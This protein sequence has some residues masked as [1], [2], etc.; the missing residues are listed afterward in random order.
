M[1]FLLS[2][3]LSFV[4]LHSQTYAINGGPD[5]NGNGGFTPNTIGT[6]AGVL[7]PTSTSSTNSDSTDANS[8]GLFSIGQPATGFAKGGALVFIAGAA[9]T[10]NLT[11]IIDPNTVKLTAVIDAIST[12]SAARRVNGI[13]TYSAVFASGSIQAKLVAGKF[14]NSSKV[15]LLLEGTADV[16]VYG[17]VRNDGSPIVSSTAK[18]TVSGFKQA[19]TVVNDTVTFTT[20][21]AG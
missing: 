7:V 15:S 12:Y 2:L 19:T 5:Y 16:A 3:L 13:L 8:I 21:Q 1:R 20:P 4:L 11:G 10:G 18:Y 9:F 14:N 6:Y 17:A